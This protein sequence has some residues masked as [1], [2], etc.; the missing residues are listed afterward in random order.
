[1]FPSLISV[2]S[3]PTYIMVLKDSG[4]LVKLYAA[5]NV[6]QYNIVT[7]AATQ[8]ECLEKYKAMLGVEEGEDSSGEITNV[9]ATIESIRYIDIDG[10]TYIYLITT[11]GEIFKAKASNHEEMLLL[12]EGDKVILECSGKLII[13]AQK[14]KK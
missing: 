14:S 2:A 13:T 10:N 7:T 4:G 1:M 8:K 6:E 12:K 3:Q 5:V 9:A 11:N